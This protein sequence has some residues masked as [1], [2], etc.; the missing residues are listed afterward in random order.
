MG[1]KHPNPAVPEMEVVAAAR[2]LA[3]QLGLTG[4]HVFFNES[5]VPY[6]DRQNYLMEADVGVSTHF[7][8]VETTFSFRTR[9]LDYLWAGLPIVT[10][11]GDSFGSLVERESLG[12]SVPERDQA[13]LECALERYLF[14]DEAISAARVNVSRIR[15][16]FTWDKALAPLVEFCRNPQHAADKQQV[17][18]SGNVKRIRGGSNGI[19]KAKSSRSTGLRRDI[20]RAAYYFQQGGPVAVVERIRAR[21]DRNRTTA[22]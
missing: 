9:I 5:W 15:Q 18:K 13:A 4:K 14:D 7:Q 1:V 6:G 16:S 19:P 17:K 8:H 10:T 2:V 11:E 21:Q 12:A 3:E 20:E 22:K